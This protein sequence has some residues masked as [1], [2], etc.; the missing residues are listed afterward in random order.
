MNDICTEYE[1]S[2]PSTS[3]NA[4]TVE[5]HPYLN[6]DGKNTGLCSLFGFQSKSQLWSFVKGLFIYSCNK[7][8]NI[9]TASLIKTEGKELVKVLEPKSIC[10]TCGG[11]PLISFYI[12][13]SLPDGGKIVNEYNTFKNFV[14]SKD[15]DLLKS[16]D[17]LYYM[18]ETRL[19]VECYKKHMN[20]T[21][22]KILHWDSSSSSSKSCLYNFTSSFPEP[23]FTYSLSSDNHFSNGLI[24]LKEIVP[25]IEKITTSEKIDFSLYFKSLLKDVSP[26]NLKNFPIRESTNPKLSHKLIKSKH[27]HPAPLVQVKKLNGYSKCV[28][29]EATNCDA[30]KKGSISETESTFNFFITGSSSS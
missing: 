12:P 15:R 6:I 14:L 17:L 26:I 5:A 16:F 10:C 22:G 13:T 27:I 20:N 29:Q 23:G 18:L 2:N 8:S 24:K 21:S 1:N 25:K 9:L 30:A 3:D 7:C 4:A 11:K 19:A 28:Q